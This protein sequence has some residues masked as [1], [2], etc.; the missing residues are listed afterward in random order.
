MDEFTDMPWSPTSNEP[1]YPDSV[2]AFP[3]LYGIED[4]PTGNVVPQSRTRG[5]YSRFKCSA[6]R[7]D[8][9]KCEPVSRPPGQACDRCEQRGLSCSDAQTAKQ[10]KKTAEIAPGPSLTDS[11]MVAG[12]PWFQ[13][14]MVLICWDRLLEMI[15][16]VANEIDLQ[17]RNGPAASFISRQKPEIVRD[18]DHDRFELYR[19][20][21][22]QIDHLHRIDDEALRGKLAM[23]LQARIRWIAPRGFD[24]LFSSLHHGASQES[25]QPYEKLT[26][27]GGGDQVT[28][29]ERWVEFICNPRLYR[30]F[31]GTVN[32]TSYR[33]VIRYVDC[34]NF[35]RRRMYDMP[36]SFYH[37]RKLF[38]PI[39]YDFWFSFDEIRAEF[40]HC[41]R[42]TGYRSVLSNDC[43]GRT[44]LHFL[45][46]E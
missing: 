20:L 3:W 45:I 28:A 11:R 31:D 12:H 46:D 37:N 33:M 10:Q 22:D 36:E 7:Q 35:L 4:D 40:L 17:I 18:I 30:P 6:C 21:R 1:D 44:L 39:T 34:I 27:S 5:H 23:A 41:V 42:K 9:K 8:K 14:C 32:T 38:L 43:L 2:T 19:T 25:N 16:P 26:I 15:K 24:G 29:V 13:E